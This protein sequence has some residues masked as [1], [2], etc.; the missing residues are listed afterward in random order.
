M[1]TLAPM[2]SILI[3]NL[4]DDLKQRLRL[5]AAEHGR[6]ME[7]EARE[8]LREALEA[9]TASSGPGTGLDV[10]NEI[11]A[12]FEPLG[13]MEL[14]IPPRDFGRPLPGFGEDGEPIRRRTKRKK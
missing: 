14:E 3:R 7:Q 10:W 9:E 2:A 1:I 4:D 8:I 13:G 11:R 6:S 12:I 5:R